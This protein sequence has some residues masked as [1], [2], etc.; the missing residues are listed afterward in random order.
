MST[1]LRV[2]PTLS[3]WWKLI[4]IIAVIIKKKGGMFVSETR[5]R[6][7]SMKYCHI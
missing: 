7:I 1:L 4:W 3:Q 6:V 5:I 2:A